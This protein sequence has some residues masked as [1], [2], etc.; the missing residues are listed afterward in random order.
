MELFQKRELMY[1]YY[2]SEE[3]LVSILSKFLHNVIMDVLHTQEKDF[4]LEKNTWNILWLDKILKL[5]P[6]AKLVHIYRDPR[7]VISSYTNQAWMP[8][9]PIKCAIIY[10]DIMNKWHEI[11][12]KIPPDSFFEISLES[13][14]LSPRQTLDSICTFWGIPWSESLLETE[15]S[16]SHIGRWKEDLSKEQMHQIS[17]IIEKQLQ[18]YNYK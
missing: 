11:S 4:Y 5:I 9:D 18:L 12:K 2:S 17:P 3:S 15:M 10:G 14:V 7:D 1:N 6:E 16:K 13:L 8:A